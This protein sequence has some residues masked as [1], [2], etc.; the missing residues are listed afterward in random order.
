MSDRDDEECGSGCERP[1]NHLAAMLSPV[2]RLTPWL[3][4]PSAE[5]LDG[6]T[7]AALL[8]HGVHV[9]PNKS[10]QEMTLTAGAVI[11]CEEVVAHVE[12]SA[13]MYD[14]QQENAVSQS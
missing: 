1:A 3:S 8:W 5:G 2:I 14:A 11:V 7:I 4:R 9:P 6:R 12:L 10:R 13:V